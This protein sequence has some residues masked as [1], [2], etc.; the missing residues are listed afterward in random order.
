MPSSQSCFF[1]ISLPLLFLPVMAATYMAP[2][3][4]KAQYIYVPSADIRTHIC[5]YFQIGYSA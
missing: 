1:G 4:A 3:W 5:T 2:A